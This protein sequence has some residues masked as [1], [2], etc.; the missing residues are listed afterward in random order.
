MYQL[1]KH[2]KL[3][4]M[5][6]VML[7]VSL[8]AFLPG[9]HRDKDVSRLRN[10]DEES[11]PK[12]PDGAFRFRRLQMQ[13]EK[14]EIP[15]DGLVRA[16]RHL[17][18]M[19]AEQ[20]RRIKVQQQSGKPPQRKL[21]A[22]IAPDSWTWLGPGNIG[23]RIRALVIHPTN[24]NTMWAGSVGGGIWRTNNGG[25][26]WFPV[27]DF[28]ANLAVTTIVIHPINTG[29]MYAGTGE[30]FGNTDAIQGAGVFKSIDGGV[31]WNQLSAT[32]NANF[33]FVNR[34][35]ISPLGTTLLAGT[36][37]G[38]W[39][40]TDS[41][42]S[43]THVTHG[44]ALDLDF[45][46][47][48]DN[49]VLV[50]Q[51]GTVWLSRDAGQFW[52]PVTFNP[53]LTID[54]SAQNNGRVELAY[55]PI[56]SLTVY[57]SIN[58]TTGDAPPL[59]NGQVY[60]STDGGRNF[61]RVNVGNNL[62]G[63][64]GG[65]DNAVWVHPQDPETVIVAGVLPFRSFDGGVTF[66]PMGDPSTNLPHADHHVIVSHPGFN[67]ST[68]RTVFWGNDGGIH[69][70][71]DVNV[72]T[73][74][75]TEL[76]NNLGI[77]QFYGAAGNQ[78]TGVVIG[79]TQD[80]GTLR[81]TGGT[82]NWTSMAGADGGYCAADPT[83]SNYFYGETQNLGVMRSTNGGLSASPIYI[84]I[85]DAWC[86]PTAPGVT[87]GA[88]FIAPLVLDPNNPNT[89]L[90]GG[91]RLWRTTN[92]KAAIPSWT[93]IKNPTAGNSPI[94][95]IAV[96]PIT[97]SLILVGHNDGSIF[98]TLNGTDTMPLWTPINVPTGR[99]VTRLV[100]DPTHATNWIYATLGG[101]S[102][103]NV[104]RTTNNGATWTDITG[105][106]TTGLPDVPVL[107]LVI[108]PSNTNLL[109]VGTEIGVFTSAD[110]GATWELPQSGPANVS[111]QE[112]FWLG[113]DLIAATH[114]RGLY[115]ASGGIYVDCNYQGTELGTF[116]QPYKTIAAAVNAATTYRIIWVKP[117]NYNEQF[118][119]PNNA[120]SKRLEIRSLGGTAV[121][122]R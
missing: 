118:L 23:G 38:V 88:N 90:A 99:M 65:Y 122:G 53:D 54:S 47:S 114:G 51:K 13:N 31:T 96:S 94:S 32:N 115:R 45:D 55:H 34:L 12:N 108:H 33:N 103:D 9:I 119:L 19:K 20:Q 101:F 95:A 17:A 39:R 8:S 44:E 91:W 4:L 67:D 117:C 113:G 16:H 64:Q 57:A 24:T 70:L 46:P 107:S 93:S 66:T 30:A 1:L 77:T 111:V 83:D 98:R 80:N 105:T 112:L 26:S 61:T 69:R 7:L 109:Y 5:V 2:K 42:T 87:C 10:T 75:W 63:G 22:G 41:G 29:T 35:A 116:E 15:P 73:A 89:L 37:S 79:G 102:G 56:G 52:E 100:I 92:A 59:S 36:K 14:G 25:N 110:A 82:E 120:I 48:N 11:G 50:G 62:L 40:S 60:R 49:R 28:L 68:N 78:A 43:W 97:P 71:A 106:G 81:F 21:E 84:G 76:N 18:L 104:Y 74:G 3:L 85:G 72:A 58:L 27:N 6:G 86:P 121:I